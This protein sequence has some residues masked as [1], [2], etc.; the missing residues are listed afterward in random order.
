MELV[1]L[2]LLCMYG[3]EYANIVTS[4]L[5]QGMGRQNSQGA[6]TLSQNHSKLVGFKEQKK[7][8]VFKKK[9]NLVGFSP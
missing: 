1:W 8:F 4:K 7:Y 3:V 5:G 9:P 6:F 2:L